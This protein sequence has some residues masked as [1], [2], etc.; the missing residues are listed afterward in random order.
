M[1]E[2]RRVAAQNSVAQVPV[3]EG[4]AIVVHLALTAHRHALAGALLTLVRHS[5][6]IAIVA[7]QQIG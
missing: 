6:G 1:G 5:T 4:E 2:D 7:V 3:L